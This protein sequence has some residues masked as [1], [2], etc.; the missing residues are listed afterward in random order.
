M[1]IQEEIVSLVCLFYIIQVVKIRLLFFMLRQMFP[2]LPYI[3]LLVPPYFK[4]YEFY[5]LNYKFCIL[6]IQKT[7]F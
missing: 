6:N 5:N 2:V 1:E 3:L 7:K 4:K